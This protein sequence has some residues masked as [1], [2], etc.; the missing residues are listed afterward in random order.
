MAHRPSPLALGFIFLTVGFNVLGQILIKQGM[1]QVG[2]SPTDPGSIPGFV[3]RALTNLQVIFGLLCAFGAALA[4]IAAISRSSL[5]F[6]YPFTAL[7]VVLVL[8]LSG[9][10]FRKDIPI[11]RWFGVVIVCLETE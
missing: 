9:V 6:A 7:T 1:L 11:T 2:E 8:V 5:S 3:F 4:W 10:I